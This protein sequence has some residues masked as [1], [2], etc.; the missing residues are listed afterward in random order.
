MFCAFSCSFI[1]QGIIMSHEGS[2]A[3]DE[4]G[5]AEMGDARLTKRVIKLADRLGDAPSAS[6]PGACNGRTETQGAYRFF[7][8]ARAS[9]RGLDWETVLAPHM[10][11]T[12]ARM[13]SIRWYCACK[14]R[15]NGQAINGLG[16]L[17][18]EEQ[19]GMYVYRPTR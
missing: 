14:T 1:Y 5:G 13:A 6:I 16:S 19:R 3:M 7:D 9:K 8:Q 12:E 15:P 18:Y 11:R 10:A 4:F 2:W 17:S